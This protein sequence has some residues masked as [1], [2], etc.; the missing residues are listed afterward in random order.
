[1]L[2]ICTRSLVMG[3]SFTS[4]CRQFWKSTICVCKSIHQMVQQTATIAQNQREC[5][6]WTTN[7]NEYTQHAKHSTDRGVTNLIHTYLTHDVGKSFSLP[8]LCLSIC[9][10]E[11]VSSQEQSPGPHEKVRT[12]SDNVSK[13][14][15]FNHQEKE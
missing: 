10:C 12:K 11:G 1:M 8:L 6:G 15:I 9:R 5:V 3:L 2:T 14:D 13:M 4:S 7:T